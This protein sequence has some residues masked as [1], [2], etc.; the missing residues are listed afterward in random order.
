LYN[1]HAGG[2]Q[3]QVFTGLPKGDSEEIINYSEP[4]ATGTVLSKQYK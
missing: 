4:D 1:W 2:S 3:L